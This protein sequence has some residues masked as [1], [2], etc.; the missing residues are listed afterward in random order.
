[1]ALHVNSLLESLAEIVIGWL[2]LRHAE[3]ALAA[4][5]GDA[6]GDEAFYEGKI[7]AA[8]FFCR[9]AL[10]KARLRREAAE[11]EDGALMRMADAAF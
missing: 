9:H 11:A 1:V 2:L 6:A 10:P 5:V 4:T 7:A 8:R 3:V